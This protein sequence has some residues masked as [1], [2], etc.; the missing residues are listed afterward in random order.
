MATLFETFRDYELDLLE[1]ITEQWGIEEDINWRAD[2][3]KQVAE[4]MNHKALFLEILTS[5]PEPAQTIFLEIAEKG[6]RVEREILVRAHGDIREMGAGL[7]EKER[8]DR[9]PANETEKLFY[10][11]LIALAFFDVNGDTKEYFYIP[12]E[13]LVFIK[14]HNRTAKMPEID[15]ISAAAVKK[16]YAIPSMDLVYL[17]ALRLA[18]LRGNVPLTEFQDIISLN[19]LPFLDALLSEKDVIALNGDISTEKVKTILLE[20][21]ADL[22]RSLFES[23]Y[24]SEQSNDLRMVPGLVF[25][26]QWV[27]DPIK[28]RHAIMGIIKELP[29]QQW[30]QLADLVQ[31]VQETSPHFMR[32]GGEFEQ[33]FIKNG[34]KGSY[35]QGFASWPHV[36]GN[37]I[38]F[39]INGPLAWFGIIQIA[40]MNG[41]DDVLIFS[42]T[43]LAHSLFNNIPIEIND[44]A[45]SKAVIHKNGEIYLPRNAEREMLYHFARFCI[46]NGIN[47]KFYKFR[48]TPNAIR[49]SEKQGIN[50]PQI[51]AILR[52]YGQE[53][54]PS[55]IFTALERWEKSGALIQIEDQVIVRFKDAKTFNTLKNSI[56]KNIKIE[57]LNA[58][59]VIIPRGDIRK[60]ENFLGEAGYL[61]ENLSK[62]ND[63]NT[64]KG[65]G[66]NETI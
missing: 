25:E 59:S 7:R 45:A 15:P 40:A 62:Y 16:S 47:E 9:E 37:Y 33:W 22:V 56:T 32:S 14:S 63:K 34:D 19:S 61:V 60:L 6:G 24:K 5:L 30:F 4:K 41:E 10:R 13:F 65:E 42:K 49:R 20:N 64:N 52:K 57:I 48:M 28:P 8:P 12:D 18:I 50:I 36:E 17:L 58:D 29:D 1:M 23:W 54:I 53:P 21:E 51:K 31:W 26:G 3:A 38:R 66:S 27:N 55:N 43:S 46:W 11:A 44:D 35:L 39:L 2:Q